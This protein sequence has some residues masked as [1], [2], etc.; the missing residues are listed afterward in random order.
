MKLKCLLIT[1]V[2]TVSIAR[3]QEPPPEPPPTVEAQA[4]VGVDLGPIIEQV[5]Q[6]VTSKQAQTFVRG[7]VRRARRAFAIGPTVGGWGAYAPSPELGEQAVTFGL[8]LE[9]FKIPVLPDVT[10]I[11]ELIVERLRVKLVAMIADRFRG[12]APP[13]DELERMAIEIFEEV[14]AE[15]LGQL[16]T[17]PKLMERPRFSLSI[18]ANRLFEAEA[19]LARMRLGIGIWRFTLAGSLAVGR[20]GD[21]TELFVGPELSTHFLLSKGVRTPVVSV[22]VR[23]DFEV[24]DREVNSDHVTVGA[25]FLLDII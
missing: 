24:T 23:G 2:G 19:W 10:M 25:R 18:E 12:V 14:K 15:V 3:A 5:I 17:R 6:R 20:P 9:V 7:T 22:F 4:Q 21:D 11:K 8:A 13:Q 16:N 1:L